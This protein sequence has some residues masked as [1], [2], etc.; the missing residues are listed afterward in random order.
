MT[1]ACYAGL[2]D[3]TITWDG[4]SATIPK[5]ALWHNETVNGV[6]V[7]TG[8]TNGAA[9]T[10]ASLKDHLNT[11]G[12]IWWTLVDLWDGILDGTKKTITV[13]LTSTNAEMLVYIMGSSEGEVI[14]TRV[15][16]TIPGFVVPE[17]P[18]GSIS[19]ILAMMGALY[20]QRRSKRS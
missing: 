11:S 14:D 16:P 13:T 1:D 6:K 18:I 20:S 12:Q 4:G 5:G 9:Y 2:V 7:P 19:T 17:V 15:P 3:V 8:T 10:V